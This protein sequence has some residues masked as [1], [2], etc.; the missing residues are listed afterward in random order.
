MP[1]VGI[2]TVA[3]D[4]QRAEVRLG[5]HVATASLLREITLVEDRP[6]TRTPELGA[7]RIKRQPASAA[8]KVSCLRQEPVVL[9]RA[10]W[11]SALLPQDLVPT[12]SQ[13][14]APL[15]LGNFELELGGR[16]RRSAP[17][18][19][20]DQ[21][22]QLPRPLQSCHVV[23]A[24]DAFARD[25]DPWHSAGTCHIEQ[26]VLHG[27]H[28]LGR[29]LVE[30]TRVELDALRFQDGLGLRTIWARRLRKDDDV[31]LIEESP[32]AFG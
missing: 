25:E 31:V 16:P 1:E 10:R 12:R 9:V 30:L 7:G 11:L 20:G 13:P 2:A 32:D 26:G 17:C 18:A 3:N 19:L 24:A 29:Q 6:S 22:G 14:G 21:L 8:R 23:A 4:L 28:L 27:V 5:P 15:V